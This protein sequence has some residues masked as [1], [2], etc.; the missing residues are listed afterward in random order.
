MPKWR[1]IRFRVVDPHAE[2]L[3]GVL[4]VF[5][6]VLRQHGE[7]DAPR[8][9]LRAVLLGGPLAGS[10]GGL[11]KSAAVPAGLVPTDAHGLAVLGYH[12]L[13]HLLLVRHP[14]VRRVLQIVPQALD[15]S[16]L[17][18]RRGEVRGKEHL[19]DSLDGRLL[20]SRLARVRGL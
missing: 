16:L 3:R 9:L 2:V 18:L 19:E 5:V 6:E 17:L 11:V 1:Q 10:V 8:Q 4:Q 12:A 13:A 7:R 15:A 14:K 20:L